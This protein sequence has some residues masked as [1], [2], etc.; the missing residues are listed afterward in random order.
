MDDKEYKDELQK[1]FDALQA[2]GI[3]VPEEHKKFLEEHANVVHTWA[4]R[5]MEHRLK[6]EVWYEVHEVYFADG[7]YDMF[8]CGGQSPRGKWEAQ[9][10]LEAFDKP[11]AGW[12]SEDTATWQLLGNRAYPDWKDWG[13]YTEEKF[14][15]EPE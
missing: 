2:E 4:Y 14:H 13:W 9:K 10:L 11:V 1:E 12:V 15:V 3:E 6:E 7:K 5:L 8:S